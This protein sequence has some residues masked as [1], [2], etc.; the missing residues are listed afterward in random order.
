MDH[1]YLTVTPP[2]DWSVRGALTYFIARDSGPVDE[3]LARLKTSLVRLETSPLVQPQIKRKAASILKKWDAAAGGSGVA[4]L[5]AA[6]DRQV[7][8]EARRALN[9]AT[10]VNIAVTQVGHALDDE[11]RQLSQQHAVPGKRPNSDAEPSTPPAKRRQAPVPNTTPFKHRIHL[12]MNAEQ[13]E[14]EDGSE[15]SGDILSMPSDAQWIDASIAELK[16]AKDLGIE[17]DHINIHR[18]M[19]RVQRQIAER[20]ELLARHKDKNHPF[21]QIC[22]SISRRICE[23]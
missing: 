3:E 21:D 1:P 20:P 9:A 18:L 19:L 11:Q 17:I 15:T 5:M 14:S 7:E 10:A 4:D 6:L 16:A 22:R 23:E 8:A 12:D 2:K 13:S